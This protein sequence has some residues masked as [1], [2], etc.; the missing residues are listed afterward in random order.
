MLL[1]RPRRHFYVLTARRARAPT[2]S[3]RGA[4]YAGT[5]TFPI[6]AACATQDL[7]CGFAELG[8]LPIRCECG[9]LGGVHLS[10][11]VSSRSTRRGPGHAALRTAYCRSG[12]P[13]TVITH[14]CFLL[15]LRA[16]RRGEGLEAPDGVI[17]LPRARTARRGGFGG[18][19]IVPISGQQSFLSLP[20]PQAAIFG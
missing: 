6:P 13:F 3:P 14:A 19:P 18:I 2:D 9:A 20:L 17:L 5:G 10:P 15:Q 16:V 4:R 11:A 8:L 12:A 7:F 1:Q